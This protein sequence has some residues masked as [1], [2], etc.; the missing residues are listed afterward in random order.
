M[1]KTSLVLCFSLYVMHLKF[2]LLSFRIQF[3]AVQMQRLLIETKLC[4]FL[5]LCKGKVNKSFKSENKAREGQEMKFT[6]ER[7]LGWF[8]R[9]EAYKKVTLYF[10]G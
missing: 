4:W 10:E 1:Q 7:E 9:L 5:A 3:V 2:I 8:Y 6:L